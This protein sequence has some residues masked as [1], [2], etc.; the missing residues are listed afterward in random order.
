MQAVYQHAFFLPITQSHRTR[1]LRPELLKSSFE[2]WK[3]KDFNALDK[4][5]ELWVVRMDGWLESIGVQQEI[6]YAKTLQI[7][8]KY[9]DPE[10]NMVPHN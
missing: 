6:A 4:C 1:Q 2:F 3:E 10:F 7:P 9:L 8:V 5:D